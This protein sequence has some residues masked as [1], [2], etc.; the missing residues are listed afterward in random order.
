[1]IEIVRDAG[2]AT[3]RRIFAAI[4]PTLSSLSNGNLAGR[5]VIAKGYDMICASKNL[6]ECQRGVLACAV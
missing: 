2:K 1:V 3:A 6:V 5:H 4:S